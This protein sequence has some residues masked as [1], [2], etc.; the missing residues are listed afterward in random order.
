[1]PLPSRYWEGTLRKGTLFLAFRGTGEG[2]S[3]PVAYTRCFPSNFNSKY[4]TGQ[5]DTSGGLPWTPSIVSPSQSLVIIMAKLFWVLT[6]PLNTN[7]PTLNFH[8]PLNQRYYYPLLSSVRIL[9]WRD[10]SDLPEVRRPLG[11]S[12][13]LQTQTTSDSRCRAFHLCPDCTVSPRLV[14]PSPKRGISG[15]TDIVLESMLLFHFGHVFF[16]SLCKL[17]W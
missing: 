5:S 15:T 12:S 7:Y 16:L 9:R 1:M 8:N 14:F 17:L 3:A 13:R 6:V 2:Q 4:S 10:F 11:S